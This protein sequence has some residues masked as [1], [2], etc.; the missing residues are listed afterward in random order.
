MRR[1]TFVGNGRPR[2]V[3]RFARLVPAR[4]RADPPLAHAPNARAARLGRIARLL[5][6]GI[7]S[8]R[9]GVSG[10]LGRPRVPRLLPLRGPLTA[11]L[12]GA[13]SLLRAGV[14]AAGPLALL[15][16]GLAIGVA[17]A[18]PIDPDGSREGAIPD[19]SAHLAFFPPVAVALLGQHR[20]DGSRGRGRAHGSATAAGGQ[21]LDHR[22][23]RR[24]S[25]GQRPSPAWA[26]AAGGLHRDRGGALCRLREPAYVDRADMS[27]RAMPSCLAPRQVPPSH[28]LVAPGH[29][30]ADR[31][32]RVHPHVG[33]AALA[34]DATPSLAQPDPAE[35]DDERE[36]DRGL[37]RQ[38]QAARMVRDQPRDSTHRPPTV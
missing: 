38:R 12:L 37:D 21:R 7:R 6:G 26:R 27:R 18:M 17:V 36:E 20:R 35:E 1:R 9:V 29:A 33:D 34:V 16:A 15:Y 31:S 2:P 19:A 3:R 32:E 11:A 10:R 8:A 30:P 14:R 24:R 23:R 28:V 22:R 13:G 4:R 25:G 5:R